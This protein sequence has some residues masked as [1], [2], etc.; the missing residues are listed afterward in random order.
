MSIGNAMSD[1]KQISCAV[2]QG[3]VL[4]PLHFLL[5]INDFNNSSKQLD[6]NPF[7]DNTNLFYARKSLLE[8]ETTVNNELFEVFSWLCAN[9]LS[10]NIEKSKDVIFCTPQNVVNYSTNLKINNQALMHKNCIK[11]LGIMIDSH[12]N[13]K[14]QVS[15]ISKTIKRNIG[16]LSKIRHCVNLKTLTN[17]YHSCCGDF[18]FSLCHFLFRMLMYFATFRMLVFYS[19]LICISHGIYLLSFHVHSVVVYRSC[20][21]GSL[22]PIS[23]IW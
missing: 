16:N 21:V 3:S 5:C 4:R 20:S 2:L 23:S 19:L 1:Y 18:V 22:N 6:F 11:Y 7:A 15:Y 17:L 8:L 9:K 10:V 12:L 13:C 14:S